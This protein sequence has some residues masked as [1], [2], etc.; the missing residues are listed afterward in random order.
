MKR[1]GELPSPVELRVFSFTPS[2]PALLRACRMIAASKA[3]AS[4][5]GLILYPDPPF[6][7]GFYEAAH[8]L[9]EKYSPGTLLVTPNTLAATA[10]GRP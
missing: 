8:A 2:M 3:P 7:A 10:G 1:S 5:P 9:V 6:R 4:T